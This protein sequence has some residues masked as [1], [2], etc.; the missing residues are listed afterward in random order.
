MF[1]K[2][3]KKF[4]SPNPELFDSVVGE[5]MEVHGRIV[6]Y[7]SIRIDGT[8]HGSIERSGDDP[9]VTVAIG[10]QGKV[11]GDVSGHRILVGGLVEGN[12]Y[13]TER[14]ELHGVAH[15]VGDITYAD[16][17]IEP[18]AEV[19]GLLIKRNGKKRETIEDR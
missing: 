18:G 13:A 10:T 4:I 6:A 8:V 14:V 15:V 5:G 17:G 9:D 16:I 11:F 12:I 3:Q 19:L 2:K 1:F 7:K